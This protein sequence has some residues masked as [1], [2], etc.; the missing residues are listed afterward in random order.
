LNAALTKAKTDRINKEALYNQVKAA[1]GSAVLDSL[2]AVQANDYI[3]K[4]KTD[5]ADLQRQQAQWRSATTN[6]IRR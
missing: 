6:G 3:Q 4:L 5:L 1:D 2:P